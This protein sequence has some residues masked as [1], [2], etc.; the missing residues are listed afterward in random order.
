MNKARAEHYVNEYGK[1]LYS[2]CLY[3]TQ[4]KESAEDLYQETFL[5][6]LSKD[7]I[8]EDE[9]PKAYLIA[10]AAN[11]WKNL[12]RKTAW[13]KRIADVSYVEEEELAQVADEKGSVEDEV[14][15]RQEE[16]NVRQNVLL[17][18][19][20]FRVVLLMHYMED[21]S[22]EEIAVALK[23]PA[24]TVKSRMNKAKSLLKERLE[25]GK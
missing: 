6:A 22:I 21:M 10:I 4:N 2:F 7:E 15:R 18:P 9:N 25:H 17:L 14:Q 1:R 24:G 19:D 5:V 16:R 20:K 23:I 8:C 13:R 12:L 3:C 11:L